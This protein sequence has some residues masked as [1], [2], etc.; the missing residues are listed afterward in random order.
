M[1]G[2]PAP[3]ARSQAW[4]DLPK[5]AP[6]AFSKLLECMPGDSNFDSKSWVQALDFKS[7]DR[8][9]LRLPRRRALVVERVCRAW[10]AATLAGGTAALHIPASGPLPTAETMQ[11]V[12]HVLRSRRV[13]KLSIQ[14]ASAGRVPLAAPGLL[15]AD[16]FPRLHR[17]DLSGG[18]LPVFSSFLLQCGQLQQIDLNVTDLNAEELRLLC[19]HLSALPAGKLQ[20]LD[21]QLGPP[22]SEGE[23]AAGLPANL[24][25]ALLLHTRPAAL[26]VR[27]C[28]LPAAAACQLSQLRS[29]ALSVS[30]EEEALK[31]GVAVACRRLPQLRWLA[32]ADKRGSARSAEQ[33]D[34]FATSLP[35]LERLP[36]RHL[37][38]R[39]CLPKQAWACPGLTCLAA[40]DARVG[41]LP[42]AVGP[43][44]WARGLRR[45]ALQRCRFEGGCFPA[46]LCAALG[47]LTRLKLLECG[48]LMPEEQGGEEQEEQEKEEQEEQEKEEQEQEEQE[49]EAGGDG[50]EDA[51]EGGKEEGS[52]KA[53][54]KSWKQ[55]QKEQ[56][57]TLPGSFSQLSS[58][59]CLAISGCRLSRQGLEAVAPLSSLSELHLPD[60][61]LEWLPEG[62]YLRNLE[63]LDISG[64]PAL[65]QPIPFAATAAR[66]LCS[67]RI[68]FRHV[69]GVGCCVDLEEWQDLQARLGWF[70]C[71]GELHIEAPDGDEDAEALLELVD[72][73]LDFRNDPDGWSHEHAC[74]FDSEDEAE[75][76]GERAEG[77]AAGD[78]NGKGD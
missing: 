65:D 25:D 76:E 13:E 70:K 31:L 7:W 24:Q 62:G 41:P 64:N 69:S 66:H 8:G 1:A 74:T 34:W 68:D 54:K 55:R 33:P 67:L 57:L 32:L 14:A 51:E 15:A 38:T 2:Q 61:Q 53:K 44:E 52:K 73:A 78:A 9:L 59:K 35:G 46:P 42:A 6:E 3:A 50:K 45:L 22:D 39:R 63:T 10:R 21:L 48:T 40:R 72:E 49:Q 47:A 20:L 12:V 43:P 56:E 23:A 71:L 30:S 16:T 29:A 58:L 77:D 4:A 26:L 11:R 5:L 27:G 17:L 36:L 60:C 37:S 28:T 19:F 18:G 75:L